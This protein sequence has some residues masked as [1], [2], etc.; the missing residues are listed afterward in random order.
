[1]IKGGARGQVVFQNVPV[2]RLSWFLSTQVGRSVIDKT[3]LTG[4]YDFTLDWTRD[5]PSKDQGSDASPAVAS[6]LGGPGIMTAVREQLGLRL[7]SEKGATEFLT[8]EHAE[9]P[10]EN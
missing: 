3:G 10:A 8:I 6:D 2:S 1:V 9:K 4:N 7:E 5:S